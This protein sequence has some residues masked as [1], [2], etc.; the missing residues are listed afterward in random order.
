MYNHFRIEKDKVQIAIELDDVRHANEEVNR[1]K[2]ASD[3]SFKGLTA[4]YNSLSKKLDELQFSLT[5]FDNAKRKLNAENADLLRQLQELDNTALLNSRNVDSLSSSLLEQKQIYEEESKERTLLLGKYRNLEHQYDGLKENYEDEV[6]NRENL[7]NQTK[8]AE[9]EADLGRKKFEIDG[10]RR[11]EEL[12][13]SKQKLQ[14]RLSEGQNTINNLNN[15]Q[16]M[17]EKAKA[18]LETE[19]NDMNL[20]LDQAVAHNVTMEK[21]AR[22]FDR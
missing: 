17:L 4:E 20:Q 5:D 19:L 6:M 22:Q 1:S 2:S 16:M 7:I 8:K 18:K 13:M 11:I 15:K 14:S 3:K 12:E 10:L 21:R 9:M